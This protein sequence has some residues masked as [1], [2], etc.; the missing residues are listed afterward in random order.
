MKEELYINDKDAWVNWSVRLIENS[1]ENLLLPAA[2]KPYA[3]NSFRSQPG[4]QVFVSNPQPAE[5]SVQLMFAINCDSQTDYLAK[6][7]SFLDE[8]QKGT[9]TIKVVPL[10]TTYK[11]ILTECMSLSVGTGMKNGKLS[12][13][14]DEPNIKDRL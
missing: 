4:K 14:F 9:L 13:K 5:R 11:L 1:Y 7:K 3:E 12:V 6:Y 2:M 8:L 10:K